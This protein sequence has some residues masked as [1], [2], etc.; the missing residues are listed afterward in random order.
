MARIFAGVPAG[1][2]L[3]EC[4]GLLESLLARIALD[5]AAARDRTLPATT[6]AEARAD[7]RRLTRTV[8]ALSAVITLARRNVFPPAATLARR[9]R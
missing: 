6:R 1:Q 8:K 7:V 5:R 2:A 9:V 4:A 3:D